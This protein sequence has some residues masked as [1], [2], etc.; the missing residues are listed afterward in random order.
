MLILL[1]HSHLITNSRINSHQ[2]HLQLLN[3]PTIL[4]QKMSVDHF[5]VVTANPV[6]IQFLMI[7]LFRSWRTQKWFIYLKID[8]RSCDGTSHGSPILDL[9]G[10]NVCVQVHV[11]THVKVLGIARQFSDLHGIICS[12]LLLWPNYYD[13]TTHGRLNFYAVALIFNI[14]AF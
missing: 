1:C 3:L 11:Y 13:C 6:S 2:F 5:P 14:M 4:C 9:H 10:I 8:R 7:P 12:V